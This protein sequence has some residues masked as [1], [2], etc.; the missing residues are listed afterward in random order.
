MAALVKDRRSSYNTIVGKPEGKWKT[1]R[2]GLR[3]EMILK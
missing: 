1:G 3:K 2:C